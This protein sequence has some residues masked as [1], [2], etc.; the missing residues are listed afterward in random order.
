MSKSE[1]I[2]SEA[3]INGIKSATELADKLGLNLFSVDC[4][5][6]SRLEVWDKNW[7]RKLASGWRISSYQ[8]VKK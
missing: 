5:P 1:K 8:W 6:G 4:G 3:R 7:N 2:I